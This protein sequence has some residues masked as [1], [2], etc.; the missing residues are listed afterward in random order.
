MILCYFKSW[1]RSF[2]LL[3]VLCLV[4]FGLC[5]TNNANASYEISDGSVKALWHM[6]NNANDAT[7][8]NNGVMSGATYTTGKVGNSGIFGSQFSSAETLTGSDTTNDL[9]GNG[10]WSLFAWIYST[11]GS[12][13]RTIFS[14]RLGAST[15]LNYE[16]GLT[17]GGALYYYDGGIT[18]AGSISANT[19][20]YV[21]VTVS[22]N[23]V[24]FWI[25]GST[26]GSPFLVYPTVNNYDWSIG[27]LTSDGSQNFPGKIDEVMF[28]NTTLTGTDVGNLYNSGNGQDVCLTS[29]CASGP[30]PPVLTKPIIEVL[31]P[32]NNYVQA[33]NGIIR[34][35]GSYDYTTD[36]TIKYGYH[37]ST[38]GTDLWGYNTIASGE[39]TT[40]NITHNF[41]IG[42]W[43]I[44]ILA[45]NA[46]STWSTSTEVIR[47]ISITQQNVENPTSTEH[48]TNIN[49]I[50]SASTTATTTLDIGN[51]FVPEATVQEPYSFYTDYSSSTPGL[52]YGRITD[53]WTTALNPLITYGERFIYFF[54]ADQAKQYGMG[55]SGRWMLLWGYLRNLDKE[56]ELPIASTLIFVM[57]AHVALSIFK[58]LYYIKKAVW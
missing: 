45:V 37:N 14:K 34:I 13:Y 5:A 51:S 33:N 38:P 8:N 39:Q 25:D 26:V 20:H 30:Q 35:K 6:Q 18:S 52:L 56:F 53:A 16:L 7:G 58:L 55:V 46:S 3:S 50:F 10:N 29:G 12:G 21:G 28:F 24:Q 49:D 42:T 17:P 23:Y 22:S 31:S 2:S 54:N 15:N 40:F 19:W 9:D 36:F 11:G 27:G 47:T 41:P 57:I 44:S 32:D 48:S 4:L 1:A 43:D